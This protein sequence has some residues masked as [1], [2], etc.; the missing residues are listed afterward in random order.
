M[1]MNRLLISVETY[2]YPMQF[3]FISDLSIQL[4]RLISLNM[5]TVEHGK[6][7]VEMR[8]DKDSSNTTAKKTMYFC[9]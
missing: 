4:N 6:L 5:E 8:R 9:N 3:D 1:K 7:F 2:Q